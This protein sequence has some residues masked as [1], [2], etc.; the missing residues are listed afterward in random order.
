MKKLK[1]E[2]ADTC[3]AFDDRLE[4][5]AKLK[6]LVSRE[7]L[8]H[9][10]YVSRLA[11]NM[12]QTDRSWTLFKKTEGQLSVLRKERGA[13]RTRLERF[14]AQLEEQRH[15]VGALEE[16][17]RQMEKSFKR[18]LQNLCNNSFDQDKLKTFTQLYRQRVYPRSVYDESAA[19]NFGEQS[20]I[21]VSASVSN[22][23]GR[24]SSKGGKHSRSQKKSN[25]SGSNANDGAKNRNKLKASK[26]VSTGGNNGGKDGA[27]GP[28][29]QAAQALRSSEEAENKGALNEK[30]PFLEALLLKEKRKRL[31]EAQIP[32]LVAQNMELDCPEGFDVD[33]FCW[34]KLQELRSARIEKEIE[35]KMLAIDLEEFRHKVELVELQEQAA[36]SSINDLKA[37]RSSSVDEMRRLESDL[38][39]VVSLRQGQDEVDRD[40]VVTD[41][42]DALL[43]PVEVIAKYNARIR[44]LG[45]EKI[46]I[47]SKIKQFRRKI[48]LIDWEAFHHGLEAKHYESYLTDLQLFRVTRELQ[49]IIRE[50][51]DDSAQN[52]VGVCELL[53]VIVLKTLCRRSW[54]K[55]LPE[56]RF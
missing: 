31:Q 48:N 46:G 37:V 7:I 36:T 8:C 11:V 29:Q 45:K 42:S 19:D 23:R 2:V 51:Q 40:A 53:C 34:S 22:K 52:K 15:Q 33:Q 49:K 41:Y 30:D 20:E 35:A 38:V 12:A 27:L 17:G 55:L 47:L 25:L 10:S 43:L 5:L 9:E 16:E 4:D 6:V 24:S 50:A 26:N 28:M 44:E 3:R 39:T 18:D 21:D 32:L 13:L 1:G 54:K 56:S 14:N